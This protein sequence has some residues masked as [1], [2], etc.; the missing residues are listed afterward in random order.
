MGIAVDVT[1]VVAVVIFAVVGWRDGLI[2]AVLAYAGFLVGAATGV[3]LAPVL[4]ARFN[5]SVWSALVAIALV[6][7]GAWIGRWVAVKVDHTLRLWSGW[8]PLDWIDRPGGALVGA[9]AAIGTAWML[10]LAVA[11][12]A[13]PDLSAAVSRSVIVQAM[14][15]FPPP[16]SDF[17]ADEFVMLGRELDYPRY[18]DVLT[19]ER[20]VDADAAPASVTQEEAILDAAPSVMRIVAR[21]SA[22]T[23]NEGTGFVVAPGRLMTA[24]HVVGG[25]AKITVDTPGGTVAGKIVYC[26]P[27]HDVAVVET[28]VLAVDPLKFADASAGDVAAT[29]GF[30]AD[31]PKTIRPARIRALQ[32]W[33]SADIWGKG[34]YAHDGYQIRSHVQGGNSGGP[35]VDPRGRA[36]G[37]VVAASRADRMTGYVLTRTQVAPA[38]RHARSGSSVPATCGGD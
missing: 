17:I 35:L 8:Q 19:A 30:P 15:K 14:N 34:R 4:L 7:A 24:A 32:D 33:Q 21:L 2:R 18:V 5:L 31:G 11:N 9:A 3:A 20:I 28:S 1:I 37:V 25:A 36:L 26:D 38:L 10:A 6:V 16:F 22:N 12:S 27:L 29:I 23:A 13:V